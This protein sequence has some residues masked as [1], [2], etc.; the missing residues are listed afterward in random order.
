[1][2]AGVDAPGQARYAAQDVSSV[3]CLAVASRWDRLELIDVQ[4]ARRKTSTQHQRPGMTIRLIERLCRGQ[5]LAAA[6]QNC[7]RI[8]DIAEFCTAAR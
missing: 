4:L 8:L 1:V 3:N 5:W 7:G 6:V 2:P